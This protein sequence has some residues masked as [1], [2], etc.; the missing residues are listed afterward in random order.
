MVQPL[1]PA[2]PA[3]TRGGARRT[4]DRY[5][6]RTVFCR[7]C[8]ELRRHVPDGDPGA[9]PVADRYQGCNVLGRHCMELRQH[10]REA[11][12]ACRSGAWASRIRIGRLSEAA[13]VPAAA[14][15]SA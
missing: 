11:D 8:V 12:P 7:L 13:T 4:G 2:P 14:P 5:E 3:A 15:Q 10:L 1:H 9:R 6:G